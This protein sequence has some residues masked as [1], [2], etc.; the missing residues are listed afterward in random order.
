MLTLAPSDDVACYLIVMYVMCHV[1][2]DV[3]FVDNVVSYGMLTSVTLMLI[4]L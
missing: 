3:V 2:C 1:A 4:V